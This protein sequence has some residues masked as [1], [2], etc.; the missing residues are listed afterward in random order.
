MVYQNTAICLLTTLFIQAPSSDSLRCF[1]GFGTISDFFRKLPVDCLR[2]TSQPFFPVCVKIHSMDYGDH[3]QRECQYV[4]DQ[5]YEG[6]LKAE[7]SLRTHP[8]LN[9][10]PTCSIVEENG[11]QV[12]KCQCSQELCNTTCGTGLSLIAIA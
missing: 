6:V 3:V 9:N 7:H 8:D 12:I 5:D 11:R 2:P 10:D 4:N 1:E